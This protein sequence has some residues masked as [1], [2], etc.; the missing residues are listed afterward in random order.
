MN[1]TWVAAVPWVIFLLG[2]AAVALGLRRARRSHAPT[3][4]TVVAADDSDNQANPTTTPRC[5]T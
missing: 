4:A 5:D 2:V 1:R 3:P